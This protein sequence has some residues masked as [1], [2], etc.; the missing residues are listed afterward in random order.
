MEVELTLQTASGSLQKH[1]QSKPT[2]CLQTF[3][4]GASVQYPQIPIYRHIEAHA[5]QQPNAIALTFQEQEL[6]YAELN[7]RANQLA[8]YL[9]QV[10][11]GTEVRVAV[12]VEPSLE[13]M[14]SLL[15]IFKAGGVYLPLDPTHPIDRLATILEETQPR[16]LLTQSH[17]L[18]NLPT[19]AAQTLC[20]DQDWETIQ[21][22]PI[23]SPE[24]EVT[25]DQS[26]H[27]VYTSGTTGKPKGVIT[28]HR[29]LVNYLLVA[30][31]QF[32]FDRQTIMPAIARF[33]FSITMFELLSPLVAGG[34]LVILEREHILDFK[35]MV[36]TLEQVTVVHTSPSL[37]Q[38]LLAYI[39]DQG[40]DPQKFQGLKH[41]STGGDMVPAALL[42]S[43]KHVFQTAEIY[44]I[45]GCSEVSCMGCSY[46]VTRAHLITK[47]QVGK[48][49]NNV[50]VR[51]YDP[52]QNLV[53]IGIVGEI[54]IGGAGVTKGYL[55][56]E[57]LTQAKFVTIDGQR[58]YRTG[59]L[60]RFDTDG[61][62]EILGRSDFQIKL[63]GIRIELGEI[64]TVLRQAPG[65]REGIVMAR[66]LGASEKSLVAYVVLNQAQNPGIAE[67]R[68]FLE[69]KLPDYMI[70]A[71]FVALE[72][73]PVNLNQK[74][75]RRALPMPTPEN[76]LGFKPFVSPR[77]GWEQQLTEIWETVLGICPIGIQDNFFE[78][79][80]HSLL[81]LSLMARIETVFG[82]TLPLSTLLTEATIERLA[83]LLSQSA[84]ADKRN[85]LVLLRDG[86]SQPP[87]FLI[88]DGEGETLLYRNLAYCLKPAHP[89][90]GIQPYSRGNH[91][92][93]HT[94]VAEMATY[95][96]TQI[97]QIQPEGP[98]LLGGLC[99]GGFL[100]FEIAR[101]LQKQGQPTAMVAL[102]DTADVEASLRKGLV[103]N[104]RL[105]R[106]SKSLRQS[107]QL[108]LQQRL[109]YVLRKA[110]QKI[111]NL[112]TY[113]VQT[114]IEKAQN[115]FIIR[116]FRYYLDQ[117]L[118]LPPFLNNIPVRII[119][120]FAER[121][122]VPQDPYEGE[123]VLFLATQRSS[124]FDG[125]LIDDT[126]Y[127]E[128]YS[129]PLLGWGNR[130]TKGVKVYN[131]PGGHS[132]MLQNPNVQ[133]L[134]E[135]MQTYIDAAIAMASNS[136]QPLSTE[137]AL[138]SEAFLTE[139]PLA[140]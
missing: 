83:A 5:L 118:P 96:I 23:H 138:D 135:H 119:L 109:F 103:A 126:P 104:Q 122:Y 22:F 68:Q 131:I 133:V 43:M 2:D 87:I 17:L 137:T 67:I 31:E 113:E 1:L 74:V 94:R 82:K 10:G 85:S 120:K 97:R 121:E 35:R 89:V 42:E 129:D 71:A 52:D 55:N 21:S 81:A 73:M 100:A 34:T 134:A 93:L 64:E 99:V 4:V 54:Y 91:P 47:S 36:Q 14:V 40:L 8:H 114:S 38:K 130:A 7:Q 58:F 26:S 105:S 16:V 39:Q 33:T 44:V 88:H 63:R 41:V 29:N 53:P 117:H 132:S 101:Q 15:G 86:G 20:L 24:T 65:V 12:C 111:S 60:G 102:I 48:P 136:H 49:F 51:L 110:S 62:L 59:D 128:M 90:Y 116:L 76:L 11:V 77:D 3:Q 19:I 75:D 125:T 108:S 70:P 123:I 37:M 72:A 78:I 140:A 6:T 69:S 32:G 84:Q 124:N 112:V 61:N 56:R 27:L 66:E 50:S 45:Y 25:L 115:Q 106:F 127:A 13:I 107:Q 9:N 98:Y 95:Y 57:E 18:P 80:G 46:P 139:H 30:Q 28:S 92:I 79:G